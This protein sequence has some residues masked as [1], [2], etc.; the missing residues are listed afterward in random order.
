[1]SAHMSQ[2]QDQVDSLMQ[3]M[4]ALRNETLRLAP[5]QDRT[6]PLPNPSVSP[7]PS[8]SLSS[9]HKTDLSHPKHAS[10]RGP[11]S[12][13]FSLDVANNTIHEMGY[14]GI[15]EG[16]E[17]AAP[18]RQEARLS[19]V[20]YGG[21]TEPLYEFDKD[22]LVRLCRAHDEEVG[23]MYPVV[24][25]QTVIA[26]AK[27]LSATM[28]IARRNGVMTPLN[29][30]KTLILKMVMCCALAVEEHGH[31][32]KA[33]RVYESCESVINRKLMAD[34]TD[35]ANL[36]LLALL[37]GYRFLSNDEILAWRVMGQVVRLCLE[38][39]THRTAGLMK[40]QNEEQRRNALV[41][42]WSAY[43]L[44]RRWAFGT[45]LPY[46]VQDEEI[47][48]ELPMPVRSFLVTGLLAMK[49]ANYFAPGRISVSGGHGDLL[50]P[51]CKSLASSIALWT[52]ARAGTPAGGDGKFGP[53]DHAMV[54]KR[55]G[56]GQVAQLG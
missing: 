15:G 38:M 23:I 12:T 31:S 26:H 22:E 36:P 4:S 53:R 40:I 18:A 2:L 47:D 34:T 39:G 27:S 3:T 20:S 9:L 17:D 37:A 50:S 21:P 33:I 44:D 55:S 10:F 49:N 46:V 8:T 13:A 6:L 11:T 51:W 5:I 16:G 54:R 48:P 29:D 43:V 24:S 30:D 28:E 32:E 19:S 41:S 52:C 14:K 42:F 7:S 35:V 25:I 1:M 56:G 45:G